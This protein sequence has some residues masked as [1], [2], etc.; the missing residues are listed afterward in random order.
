MTFLRFIRQFALALWMGSI[1][2]FAA[3]VAPTAFSV[4]P[5]RT[6]A[7]QIVSHSIYGLHWIGIVC[8]LLFLLCG[9]LMAL[10]SHSHAPFAW[11]DLLLVA[12]MAITLA[13]HFGVERRMEGLRNE[14][15]VVEN[16]PRDDA[17][18]VEFNRLH[19]WSERMEGSVFF[20]GA[21]LM[22]WLAKE[23]A[24]RG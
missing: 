24:R 23:P 19:V 8:G 3:V 20:L 7:G 13:A 22:L 16:V 5:S 9:V 18:R 6:M 4:L 10:V 21:A 12:M 2:F 17:R 11:R 1:F 15:G 14:M